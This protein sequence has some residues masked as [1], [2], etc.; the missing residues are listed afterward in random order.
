MDM[1]ADEF[2][3]WFAYFKLKAEREK[4]ALKKQGKGKGSSTPPRKLPKKE[5]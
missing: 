2:D 4:E 3:H 5:R 1:P